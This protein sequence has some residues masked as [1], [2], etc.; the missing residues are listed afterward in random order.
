MSGNLVK[1]HEGQAENY[2]RDL[3][4][5]EQRI[6]EQAQIYIQF[7][8]LHEDRVINQQ[9]F[10]EAVT[11]LDNLQ[12][13]KLT[14]S[15]NLTLATSNLARAQRDFAVFKHSESARIAKEIDETELELTK[16]RK[17]ASQTRGFGS[18]D[19]GLSAVA[20]YKI[21]RRNNAG[22]TDVVQA[23]ETTPVMPGDIIKIEAHWITLMLGGPGMRSLVSCDGAAVKRLACVRLFANGA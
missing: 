13:D 21:V 3:V 5:L 9:R 17:L 11:A 16:L 20:R 7:N 18:D 1:L 2:K 14:T 15:A 23:G 4:R 19:N 8:R 10:F 12:R 22:R 6:E